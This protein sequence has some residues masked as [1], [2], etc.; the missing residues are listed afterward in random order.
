M[1]IY[2]DTGIRDLYTR[3]IKCGIYAYIPYMYITLNKLF[4]RSY[5]TQR[6]IAVLTKMCF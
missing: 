2:D 4:R 1:Y 3:F 6:N 5:L